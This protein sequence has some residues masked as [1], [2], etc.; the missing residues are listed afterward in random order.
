MKRFTA[1]EKW[2]KAWFRALSPRLKCLWNY[3]CDKADAAGFWEPDLALASFQIGET[4]TEADLAHFGDRIEHVKGGKIRIASFIEFQ[5]GNLSRDC[6]AH[7]PV[8]RLLEKHTLSNGIPKAIHSLKEEDKDKEEE[9]D[10]ESETEKETREGEPK[11]EETDPI[12]LRLFAI[13]NRRVTRLMDAKEAKAFRAAAVT[14]ED[15]GTVEEYYADEHHEWEGRDFRRRD[16]VTLL[17]NW[18]SEVDRAES[19]K[20]FPPPP[21]QKKPVFKN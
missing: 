13:F 1:T 20:A 17:N 8:F 10:K 19:W 9:K 5:Y 6:K 15:L 2:D 18:R 14:P 4:V 12:K 7:G 3:L 16:L 21:P 11:K